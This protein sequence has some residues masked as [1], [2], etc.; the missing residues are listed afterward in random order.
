MQ[1]HMLRHEI[2]EILDEIAP[3]AT[4]S[5]T[6]PIGT[7]D[8]YVR[9]VVAKAAAE[10][11]HLPAK[12]SVAVHLSGHGLPT[13]M[14]GE[15]D[16]GADA[17]HQVAGDLFERTRAAIVEDVA[18]DGELGVFHVYGDGGSGDDDPDDEVDS[19]LEALAKRKDAGYEFVIDIPYEFDSD[20][21]DTLIILRAGYGR[22]EGE[23]NRRFESR[24]THDGLKVEI[25]NSSF[26]S[27]PKTAAYEAVIID[28]VERILDGG[29]AH[30]H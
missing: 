26:G 1:T 25:T 30:S 24:F 29:S 21:R 19:P 2:H 28:E 6:A 18:H 23:W 7:T 4:V 14:C 13:D 10:V 12:A 15:Y 3:D 5:Y 22:P 11:R 20:S 27:R 9:A 16:C 8:E 17:Y